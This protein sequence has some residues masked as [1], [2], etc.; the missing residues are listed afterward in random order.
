MAIVDATGHVVGRLA[1]V[2]AKRL[3]NGE[4][5]VVVNAE[6]AILTGRKSVVFEEYRA[7]HHRGSNASRMRG[8]GPRYPRRPDFML[9]RTI[10]RMMPY[11]QP[12]GREALK[13]LRVYISI[14]DDFKGKPYET[15]EDAKR[16]PQGPHISLGEISRLLGSKFEVTR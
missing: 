4:E 12:R 7:A 2:L 9:R 14:P 11:Q 3:L 13:R 6:K 8:K 5:I 16:P 1:S 10:S 15:I